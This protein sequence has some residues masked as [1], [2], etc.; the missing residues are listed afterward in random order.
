ML[1]FPIT[2]NVARVPKSHDGY[3]IYFRGSNDTAASR[4]NIKAKR[5]LFLVQKDRRCLQIGLLSFAKTPILN[6]T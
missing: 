6:K 5:Y 3:N 2:C 1:D 4:N